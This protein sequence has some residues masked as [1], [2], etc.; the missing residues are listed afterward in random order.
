MKISVGCIDDHDKEQRDGQGNLNAL[1]N[2]PGP[3]CDMHQRVEKR[4]EAQRRNK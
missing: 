1:N 3:S 4:A 2:V